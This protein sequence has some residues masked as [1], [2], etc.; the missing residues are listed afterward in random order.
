MAKALINGIIYLLMRLAG[1]LGSIIIYP[2]QLLFVNIFPSL[3][4]FSA[5]TISFFVEEVYPLLCWLKVGVI[6]LTGL[7]YELYQLI[8][9]ELVLYF[10]LAVSI[11]S[12]MLIYRLYLFL[13]G[14]EV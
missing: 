12:L 10:G 5:L 8:I 14:R 6:K 3:G 4:N 7:P 1:L 9:G 2:L 13:R 11:R